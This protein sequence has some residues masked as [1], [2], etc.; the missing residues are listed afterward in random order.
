MQ[1]HGTIV[2]HLPK[3]EPGQEFE[4]LDMLTKLLQPKE[5]KIDLK[6]DAKKY[7]RAFYMYAT[8]MLIHVDSVSWLTRAGRRR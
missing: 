4:D 3:K 7:V 5:P 6:L 2:V 1:E 8:C